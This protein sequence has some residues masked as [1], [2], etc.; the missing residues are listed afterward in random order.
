MHNSAPEL[1][2]R[3]ELQVLAD[4]A[5]SITCAQ[6]PALQQRKLYPQN[7]NP[8]PQS[9]KNPRSLKTP[10]TL[11]LTMIKSILTT[12]SL[13]LL[14]CKYTITRFQLY[15]TL[16]SYNIYS[17]KQLCSH[18][19]TDCQQLYILSIAL[20]LRRP[21]ASASP[22]RTRS[23]KLPKRAIATAS[24]RIDSPKT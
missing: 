23:A 13:F 10:I 2:N 7:P 8:N 11:I 1:A 19:I 12:F 9:P 16:L 24:F 18:Y 17:L 15:S 4:T 5:A 6:I 3:S 21:P 20:Q 22:E 14:S